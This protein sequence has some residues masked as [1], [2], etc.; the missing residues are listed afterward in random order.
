MITLV[1]NCGSSSHKY[2]LFEMSNESV[3]ADGHI[4]RI[5]QP[6]GR[7][8]Q[9]TARGTL[10]REEAMADHAVACA[11]MLAALTDRDMGAIREAGDVQAVG[12]RVVHGGSKY[13]ASV[14]IDDGV[15][16]DIEAFAVYAPLH[17]P[18]NAVGIRAARAV[19][20]DASHVAV[21]DTAFHQT[22]PA[23]AYLYGIPYE[24]AEKHGIRRYGFHGQSHKYVAHRTAIRLGRPLRNLKIVTCHVG[25]GTSIAAVLHGKSVDTS[26][27]MT[28][29][30]GVIMGTR[31]GTMDPAIVEFL[32]EKDGLD[33]R[34][35]VDLLNRRSGL[36][37][38]SGLSGDI[39]DL[40]AAAAEG[41]ARAR[42]ALD[43][44]VYQIQKFIGSYA[45]AMNGVDAVTFTAGVGEHSPRCRAE[46]CSAL[47]FL[48]LRLDDAKNRETVGTEAIVSAPDSRVAVLVVPTNEELMIARETIC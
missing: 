37:G 48:G 23:R 46:V 26:M 44:H 47:T 28:P 15:L 29:L 30:Q 40:E 34:A 10:D 18:A 14:E 16:A 24:L 5:G 2:K 25:S 13:G 38:L 39:R 7:V 3:L 20:P 32:M 35:I 41:H 31:S 42:L 1:V 12:H 45:V 6:K 4:E 19:Y 27:G 11:T 33:F 22:M 43:V 17:N 21:F 36:L 8:R 9:T